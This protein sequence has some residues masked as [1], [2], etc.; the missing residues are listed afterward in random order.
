MRERGDVR[1]VVDAFSGGH[2]HVTDYLVGEVLDA[3]PEHVRRFLLGT[4]ILERMSGPL[5]DAVTGERGSQA[6]LEDLERRG[7]FVVALDDRREWYR[8]HHLFADVL[9]ARALRDDAGQVRAGHRRA[10]AWHERAGALADAVRH[11]LGAGDPERAAGLL[12][13]TWPAKNR[14]H[15]SARWL[16]LARTLPEDVVRARPMLGMGYAWALL[17]GGELEAAESRTRDVAR[18][19][20]AAPAADA[21]RVP[22]LSTELASARVYLAQA[23]GEIPG[24]VEHARRALDLVPESDLAGRATGTALLALARWSRGDLEVA[25]GTFADALALMRR[26]GDLLDVVRGTFVLGDIRAAQ[27][28]LREAATFYE[29]GLRLAAEQPPSA[30]PEIDELHLGLSELHREWGDLDAAAALLRTAAESAERTGYRGKRRRWCTAMARVR[31]AEGDPHGALALLDEAEAH[32]V[33]DPIPRVRPIAATRARLYLA[34]GRLAEAVDWAG[35]RRLAVDDELDY[36]RE[37][38]HVTLAR[39]LLARHAAGGDARALRDAAR[40]LERLLTAAEE[41]GRAGSAIEILLLQSLVRRAEGDLRGAMQP[42]AHALTLAEPEAFLR[43]FVDEGGPVRELLRHAVVR[44]LAGA[45]AARVLSAFEVAAPPA[46]RTATQ[47]SAPAP[48]PVAVQALTARELE[49]LRLI[50]AGLR[51]QEIADRLAVAPATVKRH[52]ANA[53]G[54]L[55]A[56]HRT[57]ALARAR[58]LRVL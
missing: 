15:E 58:E 42:L 53:Y 6:L 10:S 33:R 13:T 51:N 5:C 37:Y 39:V 56:R 12:E 23:R 43:I 29:E 47:R 1:A 16:A 17:N 32:D 20:D 35:E 24:T 4:A 55:G 49:V 7:L 54:K 41:G 46:A 26:N 2:R 31:E 22:S 28:R 3:E 11:A 25:H 30:A 52:V 21:A 34:L 9:Q 44:G 18:W 8:Y 19:L 50:A 48:A 14:S 45:A 36:A 27:G 38:E 57:E 40:L